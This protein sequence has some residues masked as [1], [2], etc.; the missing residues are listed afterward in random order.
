MLT[1]WFGLQARALWDHYPT[2]APVGKGNMCMLHI[3][4]FASPLDHR[5]TACQNRGQILGYF[6]GQRS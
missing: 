2:P 5:A 3:T 4:G 1:A 6:R